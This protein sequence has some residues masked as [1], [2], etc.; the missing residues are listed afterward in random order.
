MT[1]G[2]YSITNRA[3]GK[4]YI[5]SSKN[6]EN[7]IYR[8]KQM[9]K[10]GKHHSYKLQEAWIEFGENNFEFS[11]I[12]NVEEEINLLEVE[13]D[14]INQYEAYKQYNVSINA[15]GGT[16]KGAGRKPVI[17]ISFKPMKD[18]LVLLSKWEQL[19]YKSQD[20]LINFCLAVVAKELT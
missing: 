8:H 9:L 5:G 12:Q 20:D 7:R 11:I 18:N 19:G 14:F 13:Q 3:N 10:T 6:I 16:R 4:V 1:R 17:R 15:T 2:I